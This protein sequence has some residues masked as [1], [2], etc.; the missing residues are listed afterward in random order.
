MP[1]IHLAGTGA[2]HFD[3]GEFFA[4]AVMVPLV[5]ASIVVGI[6]GDL[7]Q[8][9]VLKGVPLFGLPVAIGVNLGAQQRFP[10][11]VEQTLFHVTVTVTVNTT[12]STCLWTV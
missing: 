5:W 2:V 9:A 11:A 8:L 7:L 6:K 1:L 10:R 3:E 12:R 4:R